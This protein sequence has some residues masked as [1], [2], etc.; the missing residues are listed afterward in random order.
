M[1]YFLAHSFSLLIDLAMKIGSSM[2]LYSVKGLQLLFPPFQA[3]NIKDI[4]GSFEKLEP[5]FFIYNS[6]YA[7]I[8]LVLILFFTILI[9]NKKRFES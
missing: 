3:L 4:I 9:F 1:V 2:F 7:I 6:L 8:Y 5:S